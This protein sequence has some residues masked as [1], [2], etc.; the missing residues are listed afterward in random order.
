MQLQILQILHVGRKPLFLVREIQIDRSLLNPD[1][2]GYF[3]DRE[4]RTRI[5]EGDRLLLAIS[6]STLIAVYG[7]CRLL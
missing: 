3:F 2:L 1:Y 5:A 7:A 6:G 4:F